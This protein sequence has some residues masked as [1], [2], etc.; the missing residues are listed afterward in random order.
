MSES[1]LL[2]LGRYLVPIPRPVWRWIVARSG[3]STEKKLHFMSEEH[4]RV[5]DFVVREIPRAG[6]PLAPSFIAQELNL[7]LDQVGKILE[8]LERKMTFLF[9]NQEG[10]VEWAYPV[11]TDQTPHQVT[12]STGEKSYAA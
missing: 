9:R 2:G 7:A 4:H 8:E 6:K 10:A 12:F 1:I 11:T 5:C 3:R